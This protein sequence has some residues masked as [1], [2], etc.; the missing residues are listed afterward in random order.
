MLITRETDYALRILRALSRGE[1]LTAERLHKEE[2]IPKP[3]A[4]KIL[5][6]LERAGFV[7]SIRGAEG[8]FRPA[9]D[10]KT[11]NLLML[12]K[13]MEANRL[14]GACVTPDFECEWRTKQGAQCN[15]HDHLKHLQEKLDQQMQE[16]TIHQLI[17]DP[18]LRKKSEV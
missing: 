13:A 7:E 4:Y 17:F 8:G 10:F 11:A 12:V 16:L 9:A 5:K 3:F 6:K 18:P 14:V 1:K 2:V 15:V